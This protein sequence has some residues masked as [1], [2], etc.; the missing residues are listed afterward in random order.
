MT[1][2][3][4]DPTIAGSSFRTDYTTGM[5]EEEKQ[6]ER[7]ALKNKGYYRGPRGG[8]HLSGTSH[9][10]FANDAGSYRIVL[11]TVHIDPDKDHYL[12]C[13]NVS[14]NG[15]TEFMLDFLEIVPKS[16]YGVEDEEQQEDDL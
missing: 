6:E 13:R 8:Y 4:N 9:A 10:V 16:V 15:S 7:K 5:T 12:R 2:A 14:D 3:L 11:C 1:K